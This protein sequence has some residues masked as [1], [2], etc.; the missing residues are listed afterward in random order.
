M[1][2]WLTWLRQ[3]WQKTIKKTTK[4]QQQKGPE[5]NF[6]K[7]ESMKARHCLSSCSKQRETDRQQEKASRQS[8][9]KD[10]A[11]LTS[12][13]EQ[14]K[15]TNENVQRVTSEA[16]SFRNMKVKTPYTPED[17]HVGRNM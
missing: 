11:K 9:A 1:N 8:H 3:K 4:K 5:M 10:T 13:T 6:D 2:E 14:Q 16:D 15:S 7:P 17:G 12:E